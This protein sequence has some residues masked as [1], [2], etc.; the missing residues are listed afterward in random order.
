MKKFILLLTMLCFTV[1]TGCYSRRV[2]VNPEVIKN[3]DYS[4]YK[5]VNFRTNDAR[6]FNLM[7]PKIEG[8]SFAGIDSI[9]N[10]QTKIKTS[11]VTKV[12]YNQY[13]RA[14]TIAF[15]VVGALALAGG[16]T[17]LTIWQLASGMK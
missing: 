10:V 2:I 7:N 5:S 12:T 8:D 16:I 6:E 13:N 3:T 15:I 14:A 11:D 9:A 4:E 1:V 17:Y